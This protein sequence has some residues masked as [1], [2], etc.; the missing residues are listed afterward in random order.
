MKNNSDNLISDLSI[1]NR[2]LCSKLRATSR[3]VSRTYGEALRPIDLKPN[4]MTI[5][6]AISLMGPVSITQLS[7]KLLMER[8]TLTRN[9]K[10][11]EK[12]AYIQV[13][14][15]YGRIRELTLTDQGR[16]I[17]DKAKPLW[18]NAQEKLIQQLGQDQSDMMSDLLK[19]ILKTGNPA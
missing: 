14:D 18:K 19:Q 4:Q 7:E 9:L 6:V 13:N 17:L 10:P 5:L 12:S 8:T 11:L 15:G 1:A 16:A 2:C 3:V